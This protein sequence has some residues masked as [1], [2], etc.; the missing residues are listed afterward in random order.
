MRSMPHALSALTLGLAALTAV[1]A[2]AVQNGPTPTLADLQQDGPY[3][4]TTQSLAGSGFRSGTIYVPTAAGTYAVVAVC[5]GFVS[6]ES[7]MT[8]ISKRLATHG[9]VV[10]TI[11]TNTLLDF[12]SSRASQLLAALK[13]VTAVKT[14]AVAGK[15][16]TSRQVVSGWS[17]GGG[18]TLEA[19]AATPGLKAAL[20]Y[21][22][23]DLSSTQFKSIQVPTAIIGATGDV[24]A[25]VATF[26]QNFYN[27]I[28]ASVSKLLAVIQGSSHFFPTTASEPAS[29]TNISWMKRFADDDT[30]YGVFLDTKDPV[31]ASLTSTGPF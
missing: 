18:G 2:L 4:V 27:A 8:A 31:E 23:W 7:S 21:A 24:I 5:P 19:A 20:A 14:G 22:P 10:V 16:D 12:P 11:A 3:A 26:S 17:M 28:P 30:R 29:Y 15:I 13:A 9:F 1:P 25:P 6:G